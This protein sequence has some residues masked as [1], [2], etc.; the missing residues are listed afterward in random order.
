M[1]GYVCM[2]QRLV[3]LYCDCRYKSRL[4]FSANVYAAVVA[5]VLVC[6]EYSRSG[7]VAYI[8]AC[9]YLIAQMTISMVGTFPQW[10]RAWVLIVRGVARW[11]FR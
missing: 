2:A 9:R 5:G 10:V 3:V 1:P 7:R 4:Y 11:S 8:H 6:F